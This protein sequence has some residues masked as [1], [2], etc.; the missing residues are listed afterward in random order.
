MEFKSGDKVQFRKVGGW[1]GLE[2]EW[3]DGIFER[4]STKCVF[5]ADVTGKVNEYWTHRVEVRKKDITEKMSVAGALAVLENGLDY[6]KV[7]HIESTQAYHYFSALFPI[8]DS[9]VKHEVRIDAEI[10]IDDQFH[11]QR[12]PWGSEYWEHID[13]VSSDWSQEE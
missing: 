5:I 6:E 3:I 10:N 9:P 11:I 12:R 2:G 7:T 4:E 1:E 13:S 8:G